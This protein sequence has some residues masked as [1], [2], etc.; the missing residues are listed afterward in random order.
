MATTVNSTPTA[1]TSNQNQPGFEPMPIRYDAR[2]VKLMADVKAFYDADFAEMIAGASFAS[3]GDFVAA[4]A[5][6]FDLKQD[7]PEFVWHPR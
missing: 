7:G 3:E 6:Y 1:A 2:Q 4:V 5:G